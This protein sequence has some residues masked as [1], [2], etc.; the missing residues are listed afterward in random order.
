MTDPGASPAPI[1]CDLLVT[2]D[3]VLTQDDAR[4]V[5]DDGAVAIADGLVARVGPRAELERDCR[6]AQRLNL[7]DAML[8]PGLIN[9][10]VHLPMTLFRGFADDLPLMQW[11]EEHIWP[12][13]FQLTEEMLGIGAAI[14]C[15]ELI[16]TGCTAFFNGYFHEH[17][18]GETASA[19]GLR[20]VLGE[21]FFSFPSPMFPTA[22]ACWDTI[23]ALHA[24]FADNPLVTTAVTPHAVFTVSPAELAAS[25]ELACELDVPWQIHLAESA[26]ETALC[27]EK[28]GKR[29][30]AVLRDHGLLTGRTV[31]HHCVDLDED[32]ID[33]V[34]A[35]GATVVHNPVSNLKLG[36]GV[37]PVQAMLDAGVTV[38][39]G[40]DGAASNNQ[41]NLF[42]DMSYAALLGKLRRV[43]ASAMP[44]QA[45]LDMATRGSAA[46]L[47]QPRLGR[48][49][50]GR[51]A[52][53]IALDLGSPSMMPAYS[54]ASQV[55]YS[56]T[57]LEVCMTMVAGRV[58][59]RDGAFLTIDA[60]SLQSEAARASRWIL[61]RAGR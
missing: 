47:G 58:L 3:V 61:D 30:L 9:G 4:T 35:S 15:A 42:R 55:V 33:A 22:E 31:M 18:T 60:K 38:G 14:G 41:L 1:P 48:I 27:V 10:H 7:P 56:A 39:L 46:C 23:R 13:E 6:P 49:E 57:G 21:G 50:T 45:V 24:R 43:D 29:P 32:E 37:A 19:A 28:Y 54:H 53:M 44:T 20:A 51:P 2:A 26:S 16:R 52:D 40:T 36:S 12:V 5:L 59:Y 25:F 17:V 8:M 11:L 34:A